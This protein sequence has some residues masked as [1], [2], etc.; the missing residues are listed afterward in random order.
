MPIKEIAPKN[1]LATEERLALCDAIDALE[2]VNTSDSFIACM[3]N[4]IQRIFPHDGIACGIGNI[5]EKNVKPYRML[6]HRFPREYVES[7]RQPDGGLNSPLMARWRSKRVP[8]LVDP[9]QSQFGWSKPWLED[10]K[11]YAL[12]NIAAHGQIDLQGELTSYF[13]LIRSPGPLGDRH[14][15]ILKCLV[16]HLHVAL[17]RA[18]ATLEDTTAKPDTERLAV[19]LTQ[20]QKEVLRWLHLGKTNWEIAKIIGTSEDN[21]KYHV[22]QIFEKLNARNRTQAVATALILKI[23]EL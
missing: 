18:M 1:L 21:I 13:C 17:V 8:I 6:L 10:V 23:I 15:H 14:V 11:K 20:R 19:E 3:N 12:R 7:I 22:N 9:E 16:P 4:Q 5:A 2:L